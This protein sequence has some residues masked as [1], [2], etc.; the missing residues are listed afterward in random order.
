MRKSAR[1]SGGKHVSKSRN[2]KRRSSRA[3]LDVEK[4]YLAEERSTICSSQKYS[5]VKHFVGY[6]SST[7]VTVVTKLMLKN[8]CRRGA[9]HIS[10]STCHT[11]THTLFSEYFLKVQL[12]KR[13][14][15]LWREAHLNLKSRSTHC[16]CVGVQ[17]CM[18]AP[19][20]SAVGEL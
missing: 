8:V 3:L 20:N 4:V 18:A 17:F 9:K 13:C 15:S 7:L 12:L 6:S 10:K 11:H 5:K 16:Q 19:I 1:D 14:M 2:T